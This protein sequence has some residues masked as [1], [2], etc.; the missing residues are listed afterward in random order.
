MTI[1]QDEA[2]CKVFGTTKEAIQRGTVAKVLPFYQ[3]AAPAPGTHPFS[4]SA[5]ISFQLSSAGGRHIMRASVRLL[6]PLRF[7]NSSTTSCF[8]PFS[9]NR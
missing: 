8:L 9:V 4:S 3:L 1:A 6:F 2:S 7:L 5:I